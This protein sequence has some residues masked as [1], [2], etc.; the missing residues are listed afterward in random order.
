V[1]QKAYYAF[2][3]R[4]PSM[5]KKEDERLADL[6]EVKFHENKRCYGVKRMREA[7]QDEGKCHGKARVSRLMKERGLEAKGKKKYRVTTDSDHQYPL[8]ANVLDRNFTVEAPDRVWAGDITYIHTQEG[9]MYLA[10]FLDLF[11]RKVVGWSL[12]K[13]LTSGFVLKA[14]ERALYRRKPAAGLLVHTDRG[15]QYASSVFRQILRNGSYRLSMSRKGNCWDNAVVESFF[16]RFKVEAIHGEVF[17]TRREL[18]LEVFDHI[19]NFYNKRRKHSTLEYLSPQM[20]E[21]KYYEAQAA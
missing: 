9:W 11:S 19:E 15:V 4:K 18:E 5:R 2:R 7:L 20:Y 13:R 10:V 3:R 1:S 8:A 21:Q 16:G 17:R 6:I 14:F 12:S